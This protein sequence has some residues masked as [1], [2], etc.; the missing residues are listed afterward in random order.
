LIL[1]W[2]GEEGKS[3]IALR[4]LFYW[5]HPWAGLLILICADEKPPGRGKE[6]KR[7]MI[8]TDENWN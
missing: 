4:Q 3:K 6:K 8:T 5:I 2:K 7:R 1:K